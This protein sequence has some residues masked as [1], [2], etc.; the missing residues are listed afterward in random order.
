MH[1]GQWIRWVWNGAKSFVGA[2][3]VVQRLSRHLALTRLGIATLRRAASTSN[4]IGVVDRNTPDILQN[5]GTIGR[6]LS[7]WDRVTYRSC[8]KIPVTDEPGAYWLEVKTASR[9]FARSTFLFLLNFF[10]WKKMK[11]CLADT[12]WLWKFESASIFESNKCSSL[13]VDNYVLFCY[14]RSLKTSESQCRETP[15]P[16]TLFE[17]FELA[18]L[19]CIWNHQ[20]MCRSGSGMQIVCLRQNS[21]ACS[22]MY[23]VLLPWNAEGRC[24]SKTCSND[25]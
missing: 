8:R 18:S 17:P 14:V 19:P 1:T 7:V 22:E 15:V 4:N 2:D 5:C 25:L 3:G 6:G 11:P 10:F 12:P 9:T 13:S 24:H 23:T 21:C 20:G 16:C